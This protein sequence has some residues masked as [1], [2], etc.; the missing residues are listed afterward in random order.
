[1]NLGDPIVDCRPLVRKVE[2]VTPQTVTGKELEQLAF[3]D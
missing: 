3:I 1:M 2:S